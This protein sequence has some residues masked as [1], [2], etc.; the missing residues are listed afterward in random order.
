[1]IPIFYLPTGIFLDKVILAFLKAYLKQNKKKMLKIRSKLLK[2]VSKFFKS[3][4]IKTIV[5]GA[6]IRITI[7]CYIYF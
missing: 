2:K 3:I 4:K 5:Y 6:I 7:L 1:M